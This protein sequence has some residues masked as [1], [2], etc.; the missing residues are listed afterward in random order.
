VGESLVE[1]AALFMQEIGLRDYL[2]STQM[3]KNGL[4][5]YHKLRP[6]NP[7]D[8][9]YSVH[10]PQ[11][12]Y[13]TAWQLHR[14]EVDRAVRERAGEVGARMVLG[15]MED[16]EIGTAGEGHRVRARAGESTSTFSCRWVIDATGRARRIGR[17]VVNYIRPQKA[18]RSC[19]WLWLAD[20]EPFM[21]HLEMAM[22]SPVVLG[23]SIYERSA[24]GPPGFPIR[25]THIAGSRGE[26][27]A[28]TS[29]QERCCQSTSPESPRPHR[30]TRRPTT[31]QSISVLIVTQPGPGSGGAPFV[32]MMKPAH[33]RDR[34]DP[35]G[36][37]CLHRA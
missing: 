25:H 16:I 4:T 1:P 9:R 37:W 29:A 10:A 28:P 3:T 12:L 13:H 34:H 8:R 27:S 20:F 18:Q 5:F 33:L 26:C 6:G 35:P 30:R 32:T 19:F 15:R 17:K 21:A 11:R 23:N 36:L 2:N 14:P 7:Q 24:T 31:C 22:R